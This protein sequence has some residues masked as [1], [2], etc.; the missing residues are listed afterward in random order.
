[1]EGAHMSPLA[2]LVPA[3]SL[4]ALV[5]AVILPW[6]VPSSSRFMLPLLPLVAIYCWVLR[7]P[8]LMTEWVVFPAGLLVD[9][10]TDGPL[11]YWALVYLLGHA[12]TVL[13][14]P[15]AGGG[16]VARWLL[17][18]AVLTG[19]S[20]LELLLSSLYFGAWADA[21]P[22]VRAVVLVAAAYPLVAG[23]LALVGGGGRAPRAG[24]AEEG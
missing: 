16:A 21:G 23:P 1:M 6:G 15:L 3:A 19:V 24:A 5:L 11:G 4:A 12:L 10:A 17:F 8:A 13:S 7:A 2:R 9:V 14:A 18:V 22:L 20:V